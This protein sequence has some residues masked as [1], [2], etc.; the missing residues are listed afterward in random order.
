MKI[1]NH[2]LSGTP[3]RKANASGGEMRPSL[4]VIHDTAGRL[5]KHSSVNW[6]ASEDCPNSA[7]VVVE[8]DGSITQMVDFDHRAWHA[9]PSKWRGKEYCNSFS[10]GIEL[11]SPGKLDQHGRAWFHKKTEPGYPTVILQRIKTPAHG[12]GWW[13]AY[14]T[15][16]IDVTIELCRALA[17][18][19]GIKDVTTHWEISPGR[20]IDTNPLF[21]LDRVRA[22]VLGKP[23]PVQDAVSALQGSPAV[24]A[25]VA[26]EAADEPLGVAATVA[27]DKPGFFSRMF[28]WAERLDVYVL[29]RLSGWGS[30][31]ASAINTGKKL[32]VRG[33]ATVAAG[34]GAAV[35]L[36]DPN[37][38]NAAIAHS[39]ASQHPILLA[40]IVAATVALIVGGVAYYFL[41]KAGKGLIAAHKDERYAPRGAPAGAR[42]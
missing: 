10:I 14:T 41:R 20:K 15:E 42:P 30:R 36:I 11:V 13:M 34:G 23:D 24:G 4:L 8:R 5:D 28:G 33:G 39:W 31:S 26:S 3:F 6:F 7:H 16:Q 1:V 35:S 21:P 19:Y 37:K 25:V 12:D 22:A 17:E 9:G 2:R 40:C 38:G 29:D 32:L 27:E 18:A